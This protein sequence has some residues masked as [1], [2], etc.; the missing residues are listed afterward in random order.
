MDASR[1]SKPSDVRI[2]R[3][4]R[5]AGVNSCRYLSIT[6]G[7]KELFDGANDAIIRS[8]KVEFP[9]VS[10]WLPW[11]LGRTSIKRHSDKRDIIPASRS[12]FAPSENCAILARRA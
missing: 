5:S 1:C 8:V 11:S 10:K 6:D 12:A 4:M 2:E 3:V 9:Q 7:T